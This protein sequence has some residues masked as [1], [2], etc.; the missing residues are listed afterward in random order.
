MFSVILKIILA[1]AGVLGLL[2]VAGVTGMMFFFWPTTFGDRSLNV[3]PQALSELRLLQ[4]EKKFLEDLPN[5][6]P[7][8]PNEAIRMNAQVS[9]DVLVQKLIAELPSQPRRSFVLGTMKSTLASFTNQDT[10]E[11]EQLLRYCERILATLGINDSGELF[12][13]WRYGFPYRWMSR[14]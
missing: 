11:Q 6:Y 4:R 10:E 7:G 12:N 13:V 9:V 2:F 1:L 5:H 8:A 14:A 3:T